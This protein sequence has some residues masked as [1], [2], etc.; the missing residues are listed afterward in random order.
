VRGLPDFT[1][2]LVA[3]DAW[4]PKTRRK[5]R[6]STHERVENG[7]PVASVQRINAQKFLEAER[8]APPAA[9]W[10]GH[11]GDRGADI[12]G[13]FGVRAMSRHAAR[14]HF[15]EFRAWRA[16]QLADAFNEDFWISRR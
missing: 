16:K 1:V 3:F 2:S 5:W 13:S 4:A 9:A 10:G 8:D 12:C 14:P 15:E 11:R 6:A 7:A